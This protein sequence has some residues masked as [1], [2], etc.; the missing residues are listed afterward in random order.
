VQLALRAVRDRE[1]ERDLAGV[2]QRQRTPQWLAR[3]LDQVPPVRRG[4]LTGGRA[5][6]ELVPVK[7]LT[8]NLGAR[9]QRQMPLPQ[10]LPISYR[11]LPIR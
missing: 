1:L 6:P 7:V 5:V 3:R 2:E 11:F 9:A 8:R 10:Q 4:E